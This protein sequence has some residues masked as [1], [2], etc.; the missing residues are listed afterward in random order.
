MGRHTTKRILTAAGMIAAFTAGSLAWGLL[1]A[2]PVFAA[3]AAKD[4]KD[5]RQ[6]VGDLGIG[7]MTFKGSMSYDTEKGERQWV[8]QAEPKILKV[9]PLGP[10]S[11]KLKPGDVIVAIDDMPITTHKAGRRFG[12][13]AP[14]E[15]VKLSVRR[16][17]HVI[18]VE[19]TPRAVCPEDHPMQLDSIGISAVEKELVAVSEALEALSKLPELDLSEMPEL[20]DLPELA[21]LPMVALED[22]PPLPPITIFR[23]RAWFGMSLTCDGCSITRSDDGETVRWRFD[24]PPKIRSIEKEGPAAEAGLE[25]GDVI[26][27]VDGIKI[28]TEEGGERFS[29]IEPGDTVTWTV[30]RDGKT[31][32][33]RTAAMARPE[34]VEHEQDALRVMYKPHVEVR[35]LQFTGSIAGADI[36]VRGD[37]SVRVIDDEGKRE[38]VI[39]T[40]GAEIR[41]RPSGKSAPDKTPDKKD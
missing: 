34:R 28:D 21:E 31:R 39:L 23:S 5:G 9:D 35:K 37:R 24:K 20:P 33:V 29:A 1:P 17:G 3:A 30:R 6:P 16:H 38:I 2:D 15:P 18:T 32:T 7:G 26:T 41:I 19:I 4:C 12:S 10:A 8:F 27:H 22:L 14:D 40:P 25:K 13:V 11:G 36:E